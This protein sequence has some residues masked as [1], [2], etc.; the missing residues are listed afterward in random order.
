[1]M[2][3]ASISNQITIQQRVEFMQISPGLRCR[4]PISE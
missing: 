4:A 2:I 1:M 3:I